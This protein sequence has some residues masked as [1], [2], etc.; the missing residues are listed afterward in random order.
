MCCLRQARSCVSPRFSQTKGQKC[1][2]RNELR[3]AC[4]LRLGCQLLQA[5]QTFPLILLIYFMVLACLRNT[6]CLWLL[7]GGLTNF[8]LFSH[9]CCVQLASIRFDL[10]HQH[11]KQCVFGSVVFPPYY[12][13][14]YI[15]MSRLFL[16]EP[17]MLKD[18]DARVGCSAQ[19]TAPHLQFAASLLLCEL[20]SLKLCPGLLLLMVH[21]VS[22]GFQTACKFV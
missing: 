3:F 9:P 21:T 22:S 4:T 18:R 7:R 17:N 19:Q 5:M 6:V 20:H 10:C 13:L 11:V 1:G 16:A 8:V 12:P 15:M 2:R 14:I